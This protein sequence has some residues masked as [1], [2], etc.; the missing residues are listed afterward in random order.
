MLKRGLS[1][2]ESTTDEKW[3]FCSNQKEEIPYV[4]K[5][6]VACEVQIFGIREIT[7]TL[8]DRFLEVTKKRRNILMLKLIQNELIKMFV[9]PGTYDHDLNRVP[10]RW[11]YWRNY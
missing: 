8:K 9:R 6:L 5:E 2:H 7:K 3:Y 4:V 11:D 10:T 1:K